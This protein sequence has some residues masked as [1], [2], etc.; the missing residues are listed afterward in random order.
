MRSWL[1]PDHLAWQVIEVTGQLDLAGFAAAN[2]DGDQVAGRIAA[3]EA[4]VA[5][6]AEAW[7]AGADGPDSQQPLWDD[8]GDD[9]E[10]PPPGGGVPQRLAGLAAKLARLR[11]AE[12]KL[13]ERQ[14]AP[15]G[16]AARIDAAQYAVQDPAR[17]PEAAQAAPKPQMDA[18][19]A[20]VGAPQALPYSQKT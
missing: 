14:A 15:G 8:G 1:P 10:D 19:A 12:G 7:L 2:R 16:P 5:A 3:V 6:E 11:A 4:G 17:R 20:A 18:Q 13:A 9:D